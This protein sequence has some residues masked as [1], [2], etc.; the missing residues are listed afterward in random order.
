MSG[1]YTNGFPLSALPFTGNER[2]P[3]DT[4]L[5]AGAQPESEAATLSQLSSYFGG[6]L[7]LVASRFYGLPAGATPGTLLT[8]TG[9]LYAYP[10]YIAGPSTIKTLGIDTTT[11]QT[12]GGAFIGMYTD[13]GAG[14]PGSLVTSSNNTTAL[15]ATSGAAVQ[16]YTPT[17]PLV[18]NSGWY[19]LASIFTATGTFPTVA[20]VSATYT[21][22]FSQLGADTALHLAATSGQATTG[23]SVAATYGTLSGINGGVFP[24][25]ATLS[26]NAG[27][28]LVILGT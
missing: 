9:T 1:L 23:I 24:A 2:L 7:P 6:N 8:V 20:D 21:P 15:I 16:N 28:P 12:G 19:W 27:T 11:G 25:S 4:N 14:Y 18:L 5:T 13:N 17:N 22:L 3:L 10:F 26:V